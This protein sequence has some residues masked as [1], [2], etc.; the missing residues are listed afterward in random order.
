MRN[1]CQHEKRICFCEADLSYGVIQHECI[2]HQ[3]A[4]LPKPFPLGSTATVYGSYP[5]C[6]CVAEVSVAIL[7]LT[8]PRTLNRRP[9]WS[10]RRRQATPACAWPFRPNESKPPRTIVKGRVLLLAPPSFQPA[11]IFNDISEIAFDRI[12]PMPR[13]WARGFAR[14]WMSDF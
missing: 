10:E 1:L 4:D 7:L 6:A 11:Q 5:T 8:F 12:W 2:D 3:F 13:A 14:A 9:G